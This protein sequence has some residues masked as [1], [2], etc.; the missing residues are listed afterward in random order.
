LTRPRVFLQIPQN[1][2]N[3]WVAHDHLNLGVCH[4]VS[5]PLLIVAATSV[6]S[7]LNQIYRLLSALQAFFRRR[8]NLESF[9]EGL[10]CFVIFFEQLVTSSFSCPRLHKL[11]VQ[12]DCFV[13]ISQSLGWLQQFDER[14]APVTVKCCAQ[15]VATQAFIKLFYGAWE[16]SR[17][18][19]FDS[20]V[21]VGLCDFW[22]EV[23]SGFSFFFHFFETLHRIFDLRIIIFEQ[24]LCVS[25]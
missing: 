11:R 18:K 1:L 15:W 24:G 5:H 2:L 25:V 22:V 8:I 10:D 7:T 9:V 19:K 17:L 14:S 4:R 12:F 13:R 3:S 6:R 21:L 16:I 23:G 20:L